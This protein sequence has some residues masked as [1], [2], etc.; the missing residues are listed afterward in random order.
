M[1]S[2]Y[3]MRL[4]IVGFI[5]DAR[6]SDYRN[7]CL[8]AQGPMMDPIDVKRHMLEELLKGHRYFPLCTHNNFDHRAGLCRG[9]QPE[10]DTPI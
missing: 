8:N 1:T 4:D 5:L 7:L 2:P 3:C 10:E 9:P 6:L